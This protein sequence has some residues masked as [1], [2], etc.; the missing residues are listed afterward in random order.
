MMILDQEADGH[1]EKDGFGDLDM[2]LPTGGLEYAGRNAEARHV[3]AG[4]AALRAAVAGDRRGAG[5]AVA[6]SN[7]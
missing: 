2:K 3:Q 5:R 6:G 1:R 4:L 7:L